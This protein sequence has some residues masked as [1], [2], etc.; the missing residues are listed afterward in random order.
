M[1]TTT[2]LS[3]VRGSLQETNRFDP[4]PK[5][6]ADR[7]FATLLN[8]SRSLVSLPDIAA[9]ASS[10][11]TPPPTEIRNSAF[12]VSAPTPPPTDMKNVGTRVSAPT[13]PP[14]ALTDNEL[15]SNAPTPSPTDIEN[16]GARVS[17]PTPP[18]TELKHDDVAAL[19]HKLAYSMLTGI[20]LIR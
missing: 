7:G 19:T 4:L 2:M 18:P 17:A 11:P 8:H 12:R 10:A 13:P 5:Q 3:I 15:R 1:T 16:V 6:G 20:T 14:T 9:S